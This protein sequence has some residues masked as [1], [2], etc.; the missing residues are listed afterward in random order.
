ME[1]V[2][3]DNN[4]KGVKEQ[5]KWISGGR[6]FLKDGTDVEKALGNSECGLFEEQQRGLVGAV[7]EVVSRQRAQG[8]MEGK[9]SGHPSMWGLETL[10]E[11]PEAYSKSPL[12]LYFIYGM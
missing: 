6:T 9:L 12:A 1:T 7:N 4:Y 11:I 10:F 2:I 8:A 5:S 3:R